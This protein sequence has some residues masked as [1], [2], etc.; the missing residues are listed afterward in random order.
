MRGGILVATTETDT[1]P[2]AEGERGRQ[3]VGGKQAERSKS[4]MTDSH[5]RGY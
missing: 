5:T 1:R 2:R 3:R 4:V